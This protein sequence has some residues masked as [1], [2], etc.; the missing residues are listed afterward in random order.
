MKIINTANKF[1][2]NTIGS[3]EIEV[4]LKYIES[5]YLIK[6]E[7]SI[8]NTLTREAVVVEDLEKDISYLISNWFY[9][10][11]DFDVLSLCHLIRQKL[12]RNNNGPGSNLKESYTIFTTTACNAACT[13]CFE[14]GYKKITMT[15][16]T[17]E[18]V[19]LY[20]L[21]SRNKSKSTNIEWFGGEPLCNKKVINK[22]CSIL[23]ENGVK[24]T[25]GITTNGSLLSECSDEEL[26]DIWNVTHIQLTFDD[27]G[28]GYD[29]I[30]N[31]PKGTF[32]QLLKT[33]ERLEKLNIYI[34]GRVHYSPDRGKEA[35]IKVIDTITK[36]SN[37][38]PYAKL[39]YDTGKKEY[40]DGLLELNE[41]IGT[42][43][44][45][46]YTFPAVAKI[47][48]CMADTN[49]IVAITPEGKLSPCGHYPYGDN[50]FGD[51]YTRAVNENILKSWR[52][53]EKAVKP[54]CKSCPLYPSCRKI[55]MCPAEGKCSEGYQY[56]QIETIKRALRRRAKELNG[57]SGIRS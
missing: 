17:A 31:L 2:K 27:V 56:Y 3:Q 9:V 33:M 20:I 25:S 36:F 46:T 13:Y 24:I 12:L 48:H 40:Y 52:V 29:T 39:L 1:V 7:N 47:N 43:R 54:E 38:H 51:V 19:A 26:K 8:Y 37:V 4:D 22:I 10:P 44:D 23:K 49:K 53:R 18:D 50:I 34:A 57:S 45:R 35:S 5:P 16:K 28:E 11:K 32:D 6:Y 14:K 41:Y 55:V 42:R 15:E 30:K 21:R